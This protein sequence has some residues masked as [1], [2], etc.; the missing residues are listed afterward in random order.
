MKWIRKSWK[1]FWNDHKKACVGAI[2]LAIGVPLVL[3]GNWGYQRKRNAE[4]I[5]KA[6]NDPSN[7]DPENYLNQIDESFKNMTDTEK[8]AILADSDKLE[9]HVAAATY[10]ELKKS[11][12]LIFK[13]PPAM[14]RKMLHHQAEVLRE[15]ALA[16]P[17]RVDEIINS[18]IGYGS[19]KGASQFYMLELSGK[20]KA[21]SAEITKV[22][23]LILS[24]QL[25]NK[26][27]KR[28]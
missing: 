28:K 10:N 20:E 12:K 21:E 14:R 18:S 11:F 9:K 16:N 1:R 8:R 26:K 3:L 5:Q 13:L 27:G 4:L 15:K 24:K 6:M 25:K 2:V 19:L 17:D 23:Y 7:V 22:M